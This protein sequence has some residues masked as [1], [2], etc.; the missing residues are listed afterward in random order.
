MG[1]WVRF[2][3][4]LSTGFGMLEGDRITVYLGDMYGN[5]TATQEVLLTDSVDLLIPCQPTK[6]IGLANNSRSIAEKKRH[7]NAELLALLHQTV[8]YLPRER[9][10]YLISDLN[11]PPREIVSKLS[12]ELTLMPGDLIA[13]GTGPGALPMKPGSTIDIE[14]AGIGTLSNVFH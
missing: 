10:N 12:A 13:C 9:Q 3:Q 11:F 6:M 4:Q 1:R 7:C 8:K 5:A 2:E 14:I